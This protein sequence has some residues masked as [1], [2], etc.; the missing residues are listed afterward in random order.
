[1]K[2]FDQLRNLNLLSEGY[3]LLP[4]KVAK[5]KELS[6]TEIL[7]F[8]VIASHCAKVGYAFGSNTYFANLIG[9]RPETVSRAINH[10]DKLHYLTSIIDKKRGNFRAIG[11]GDWSRETLEDLLIKNQEAIDKMSRPIDKKSRPPYDQNEAKK[12]TDNN[13][14]NN[15]NNKLNKFSSKTLQLKE[16]PILKD[17]DFIE[18][19]NRKRRGLQYTAKLELL[20][21]RYPLPEFAKEWE[22]ARKVLSNG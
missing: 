9:T 16:N 15:N 20:D 18:A 19:L 5:D 3:A 10:L 17:D 2:P 7:V 12:N 21:R 11:L 4:L 1:M 8:A 14:Y 22:E 6:S 13:K